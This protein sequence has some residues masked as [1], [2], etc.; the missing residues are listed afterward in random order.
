ML[1]RVNK[2][3]VY[4]VGAILFDGVRDLQGIQLRY[5]IRAKIDG[6]IDPNMLTATLSIPS[7]EARISVM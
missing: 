5:T 2:H 7:L 1:I 4:L 6:Y 3:H